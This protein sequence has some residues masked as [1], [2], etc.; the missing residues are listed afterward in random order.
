MSSALENE[1]YTTSGKSCACVEFHLDE[2]RRHGYHTSQLLHY[3]LEPNPQAEEDKNAPPHKLVL[4]FST[5][6]VVVLGW[7][8]GVLAN[9]LR[10]NDLATVRVRPERYAALDRDKPFVTSLRS[11]S[12]ER[13]ESLKARIL[14]VEMLLA[15]N[16]LRKKMNRLVA[17]T[18][19]NHC[20]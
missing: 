7:K 8:L 13:N 15:R 17:T 4:A 16:K 11:K 3:T 18:D 20:Q 2:H 10:E 9:K 14:V 12:L 6:D 5:A 19:F 1:S